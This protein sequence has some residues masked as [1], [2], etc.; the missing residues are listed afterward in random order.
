VRRIR[1]KKKS[2]SD[3][4]KPKTKKEKERVAEWKQINSVKAIWAR[5]PTDIKDEEYEG[6]YKALTKDEKGKLNQI[7][8]KAEGEI[9]FRSIL[10]VPKK[11]ADGYY[12]RFYEKSTAL[13]L[14][15]RRV[16]ISEEFDDFM[17]RYLSFI[18]GVV[19][20]DDLPLNV[21]REALAQNRVLKVMGKKLTRKALDMLKK[22]AD[23]S[24]KLQL[25]Y[26]DEQAEKKD[27]EEEK[28]KSEDEKKEEEEEKKERDM[29]DTFYREFGKSIKLGVIDDRANKVALA[30]LLRYQTTKSGDKLVSLAT[31][32]SNMP[33]KQS[34]IYYIN[35][36]HIDQ[37]KESPMLE[38]LK[39][40]GYEVLFMVDP[41]DEYVVQQLPE[42]DG[43]K[44][45][46][47]T[48]DLPI[49][50]KDKKSQEKLEEEN[51]DVLK[52]LKDTY[53]SKVEKVTV[54]TKLT[55]SPCAVT[56][57]QYGYTA[58]MER[59]MRA[60]TFSDNANKEHM[61]A[62]KTLEINPRH[63]IIKEIAAKA[64][65][66]PNDKA[67][68]DLAN[69]MLDSALLVSGFVLDNPQ[70]LS[71]RLN[72]VLASGLKVDPD[73][74]AEEEPEEKE[75]PE[76]EAESS[77]AGDAAPASG[78]EGEDLAKNLAG[79]DKDEL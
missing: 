3:D 35:G 67:L 7:H 48:K 16:L 53:G 58:N 4:D 34:H 17:P 77:P 40:K 66:D 38:K 51:K 36:A 65:E 64:K 55:S 50:S 68:A 15:V 57:G 28:E 31:Y 71:A 22:M 14:Y 12:D 11:V 52:W 23:R 18:K 42:F 63:P 54:S 69:M 26:D 25:K 27:S 43:K 37:V 59:I 33:E 73:A 10:Y 24:H 29:Y 8:F 6:F 49:D 5:E 72:R 76:P 56:T 41:L 30:K 60:Q 21:N 62:K 13:K 32:V 45:Q 75:E 74:L 9:S 70:D 47:A 2:S 78:D 20:S 44:L 79:S 1:T 19:D 46:S 39:K 61:I